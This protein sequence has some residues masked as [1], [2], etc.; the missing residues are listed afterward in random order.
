MAALCELAI[1]TVLEIRVSILRKPVALCQANEQEEDIVGNQ[2][3]T[4]VNS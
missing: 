2:S 1:E 4:S 3:Q